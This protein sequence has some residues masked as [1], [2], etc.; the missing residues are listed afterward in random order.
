MNEE[1]EEQASLY[2]L[3]LL[4]G[5]EGAAFE[6]RLASDPQLRAQVD[7]FRAS[8][9]QLAHTAAPR[10]PPAALEAKILTAIRA[11]ASAP[12]WG[13]FAAKSLRAA[14]LAA[15]NVPEALTGLATPIASTF[16]RYCLPGSSLTA[17]P[18]L[19][20]VWSVVAS[21]RIWFSGP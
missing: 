2:A 18:G 10:T 13:R 20:T 19:N 11:G 5:A 7:D 21:W 3:D 4:E 6:A 8:A 17:V 15:V 9:A 16:Q 14:S 12:S 1:L